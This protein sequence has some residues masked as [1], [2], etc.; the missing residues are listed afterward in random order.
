MAGGK[1]LLKCVAAAPIPP[2]A[3][4][5]CREFHR[6]GAQSKMGSDSRAIRSERRTRRAKQ[7]PVGSVHA[8]PYLKR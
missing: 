7:S 3:V 6:L 4:R 1:G 2:G 5:R 8:A